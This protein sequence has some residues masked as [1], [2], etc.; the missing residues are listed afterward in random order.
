MEPLNNEKPIFF[1]TEPPLAFELSSTKE[2]NYREWL[3]QVVIE[4]GYDLTELN[5]IFCSDEYLHEMN[6]QYLNHDTL[7][8]VITFNNSDDNCCIEGDIFISVPRIEENAQKFG[9][10]FLEE[11]KR[12]MVHGLLHLL[13][14][15]DKTEAEQSE[16]TSKENFYLKKEVQD[17]SNW[18]IMPDY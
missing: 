6:V 16:M 10:L 14:Y 3:H 4:E 1:H 12:V 15:A 7:T 2:N 17:E 11:L 13:G 9:V 5:Y 8:D 18:S